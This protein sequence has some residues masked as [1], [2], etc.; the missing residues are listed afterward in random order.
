MKSRPLFHAFLVCGLHF[1]KYQEGDVFLLDKNFILSSKMNIY[2]AM[3]SV[4]NYNSFF[5]WLNIFIIV[6][7]CYVL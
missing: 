6:Y 1:L 3:Q 5:G 7:I 4:P 2:C